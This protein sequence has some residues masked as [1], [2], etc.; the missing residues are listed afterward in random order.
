M[1]IRNIPLMQSLGDQS[2]LLRFQYFPMLGE[3]HISIL[4]GTWPFGLK[5]SLQV[6]VT[7]TAPR[8][9]WPSETTQS[10]LYLAYTA[11]GSLHE[12]HAGGLANVNSSV[13]VTLA[14]VSN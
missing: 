2:S 14:Y 6:M 3:V 9:K 13:T 7:C 10:M 11:S 5:I 12:L 1:V 8:A 4:C